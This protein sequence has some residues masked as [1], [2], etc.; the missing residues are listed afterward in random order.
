MLAGNAGPLDRAARIIA[1]LGLISLTFLGPQTPW[2]YIGAIPLVTGLIGR[3]PLYQL[4]GIS[5][6][7]LHKSSR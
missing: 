5:T 4:F 3:C 6:C 1:R 2:G 7:P